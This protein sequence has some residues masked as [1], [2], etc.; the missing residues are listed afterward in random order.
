MVPIYELQTDIMVIGEGGKFC[1]MAL[2]KMLEDLDFEEQKLRKNGL[3][4]LTR[5]VAAGCDQE[6]M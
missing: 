4:I 1:G 2:S 5:N 6:T 3:L